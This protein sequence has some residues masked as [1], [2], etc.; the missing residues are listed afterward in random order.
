V[1]VLNDN[2]CIRVN[3]VIDA[4]PSAH[5]GNTTASN[6]PSGSTNATGSA[7]RGGAAA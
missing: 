6:S 2:F 5:G 4:T 7:S 3:E 1:L